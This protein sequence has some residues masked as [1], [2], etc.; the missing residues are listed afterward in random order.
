MLTIPLVPL[1]LDLDAVVSSMDRLSV[2]GAAAILGVGV[3][4]EPQP[5]AIVVTDNATT[6]DVAFMTFSSCGRRVRRKCRDE[7]WPVVPIPW[8]APP[9]KPMTSLF[10]VGTLKFANRKFVAHLAS[11]S[12]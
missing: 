8:R 4:L 12:T 10:M 11:V 9:V 3:V 7:S 5:I 1:S 2:E 6:I